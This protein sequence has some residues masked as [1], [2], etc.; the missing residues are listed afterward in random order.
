MAIAAGEGAIRE[1]VAEVDR[2]LHTL[3]GPSRPAAEREHG[4]RTREK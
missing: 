1:L 2:E 3:S 4:C